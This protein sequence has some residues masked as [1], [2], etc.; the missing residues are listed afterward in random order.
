MAQFE[1]DGC[2][3]I[4]RE[5]AGVY[6]STG[7]LQADDNQSATNAGATTKEDSTK[8]DATAVPA[9]EAA[10]EPFANLGENGVAWHERCR[11]GH[12]GR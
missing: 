6:F 1:A 2:R 3:V 10:V 5:K 8:T 7:R 4:L 11:R 9:V 12:A